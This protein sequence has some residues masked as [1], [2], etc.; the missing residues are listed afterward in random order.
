MDSLGQHLDS[1]GTTGLN[2]FSSAGAAIGS[3]YHA[4]NLTSAGNLVVDG[5]GNFWVGSSSSSTLIEFVGVAAP[6]VTPMAAAIGSGTLGV[7]P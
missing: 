1:S 3:G 7:R 6:V 5:S 4:Q 2:Q